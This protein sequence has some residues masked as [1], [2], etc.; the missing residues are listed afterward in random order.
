[1]SGE[2]RFFEVNGSLHPFPLFISLELNQEDQVWTERKKNETVDKTAHFI[3]ATTLNTL[4]SGNQPS[5][6]TKV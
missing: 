2:R 3:A 1:M 4:S 6:H 5:R